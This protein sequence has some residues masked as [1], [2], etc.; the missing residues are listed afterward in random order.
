[1]HDFDIACFTETHLDDSILDEEL[2]LDGFNSIYR[3]DKNSFGGGVMI[4]LSNA[5]RA[6]RRVDLEPNN[7]ER[8]WLE[9]EEPTCRY[10]LCCLYRPPHTNSTFWNNLSRS[11]DKVNEISDKTSL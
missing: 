2:E 4:Y 1:M 11:L 7:V 3:K 9:I 5:V 8:I 6:R 10:F